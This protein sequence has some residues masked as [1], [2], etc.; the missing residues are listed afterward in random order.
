M[1]GVSRLWDVF[2][3]K[4]NS[5]EKPQPQ[6]QLIEFDPIFHQAYYGL[7][8]ARLVLVDRDEQKTSAG[9]EA[10][11]ATQIYPILTRYGFYSPLLS[12]VIYTNTNDLNSTFSNWPDWLEPKQIQLLE[13]EANIW[14][15]LTRAHARRR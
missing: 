12:F 4:D 6:P 5:Q 7:E 11:D 13:H 2:W 8:F 10:A 9:W 15:A 3:S 14:K 1:T